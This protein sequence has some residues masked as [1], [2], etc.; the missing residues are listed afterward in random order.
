M[1]LGR[2]DWLEMGIAHGAA[3]AELERTQEYV[4]AGAC[5]TAFKTGQVVA[6][7]ELTTQRDLWPDYC[8]AAS[9]VGIV[10]VAALPMRVG[11]LTIGAVN[12]YA[13]VRRDWSGDDLAAAAVMADMATVYL[14]NASQ[15]HRDAELNRQLQHA[16]DSR[17]VI[18][19]AKGVLVARRRI[20]PD[21]AFERIRRHARNHNATVVSVADAVVELGLDV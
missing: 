4:Q 19:Q 14:I 8:A 18:E 12:L 1:G 13:D 20:S 17:A 16:L 11:E 7:P 6:I 15:R 2:D 5:V 10:A 21:Q 9:R 3:V